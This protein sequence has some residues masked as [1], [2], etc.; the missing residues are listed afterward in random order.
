MKCGTCGS[1]FLSRKK[2]TSFG[3]VKKIWRCGKATMQGKRRTDAL[4]NFIGC[5]FGHQVQEEIAMDILRR[6]ID[7][8]KLDAERVIANLTRIVETVLRDSKDDG[9]AEKRRLELNL[10]AE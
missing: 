2:K 6:S 7:A 5:N 3:K 8:V 9:S 1:S 4:G 10:E